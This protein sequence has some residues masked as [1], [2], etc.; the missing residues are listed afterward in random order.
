MEMVNSGL[1][2]SRFKEHLEHRP[3]F[4]YTYLCVTYMYVLTGGLCDQLV[5]EENYWG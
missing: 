3:I 1:G 5:K 2:L 4:P